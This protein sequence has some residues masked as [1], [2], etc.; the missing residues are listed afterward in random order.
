LPSAYD[1]TFVDLYPLGAGRRTEL[2]IGGYGKVGGEPDRAAPPV[3][4]PP[5]QDR[6]P[7][8]KG[9]SAVKLG[10]DGSGEGVTVI[11]DFHICA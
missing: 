7:L 8:A 5:R 2:W 10:G 11:C 6:V 1:D 9:V 4:H 3:L